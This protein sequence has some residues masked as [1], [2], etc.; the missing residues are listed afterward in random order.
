MK[1]CLYSPYFPDHFGGGE[2]YLLDV[3]TVLASKHEV[4]LA[5]PDRKGLNTQAI[6]SA[7]QT[8]FGIDLGH[9]QFVVTPLGST[10]VS[11]KKLLWTAQFDCLYYVTDG[12]L[13]FSLARQ[14]ILHIQFPFTFAKTGLVERL[15]LQNWRVKN[16][17]SEFTKQVIEKAWNTSIT[18]VHHPMIEMPTVDN[19]QLTKQKQKIILSVGRFF[20]QLHTK[21]HDVMIAIFRELRQK[22]PKELK[23]WKLVLAGG[24]EDKS[25]AQEM[26]AAAK[27]LPVEFQHHL[28]RSE[29]VKLYQQASIYWHAA[30]FDVNETT[31]PEKV[32]H[33]GITTVEAM[34]CGVVPVVHGKGGQKE[35][36]GKS[37]NKWLWQT[38]AECLKLTYILITQ[39][40]VRAKAQE[41]ALQQ[42][43]QFDRQS[44]SRTLW[45]MLEL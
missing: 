28:Q 37:L 5:V 20:R 45:R 17:N 34:S 6:I 8:F 3:A 26:H 13:F 12:S 1:I 27:G 19:S 41:L 10:V 38:P 22:H 33:F 35:V 25:Y 14:N 32:E 44:F 23:D 42:A 7:Y 43:Q 36:L 4:F 16:T 39:P 2:K 11:W 18:A 40:V 24:I 21:R 29:L 30:G 15:K 31:Y 9:I